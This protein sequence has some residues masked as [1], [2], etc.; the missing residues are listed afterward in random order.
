MK[1]IQS[2]DNSIIYST[3]NSLF[4]A[5]SISNA[6]NWQDIA[7]EL[8]KDTNLTVIN[9]RRK[10]FDINN[11]I[12]AVQQI[13]WE[14]ERLQTS[15]N[16]LFWFSKETTAPITLYELGAALTRRALKTNIKPTNIF[17]GCNPEYTRLLDVQVQTRLICEYY[18]MSKPTIHTSLITLI[19]EVKNEIK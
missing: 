17:I 8:L 10:N 18:G 7:V 15:K 4:L 6:E 3:D 11:S 16:I 14:F 1:Y 2:P 19:N 9:P 5:G 12:I 13:E